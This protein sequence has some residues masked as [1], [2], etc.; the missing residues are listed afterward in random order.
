VIVLD[1]NVLSEPMRVQPSA[2]VLAWLR[3]TE[4][5][6]AITSISVGE[7]FT[8]IRLLPQGSRRSGLIGAVDST[9]ARLAGQVLP[10]DEP[11]ARSYA[12]MRELS[13][14]AGRAL[15]VEDGMIAAICE[16]HG[17]K[18]A[19]RNTKDFLGLGIALVN[20]WDHSP[21]E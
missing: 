4:E 14:R 10:Y 16:I 19:T 17:A 7:L 11:A 2:N 13:S 18:L 15:S 3:E 21:A 8:G 6:F 1:T 20:P 5:R 12:I 9:L